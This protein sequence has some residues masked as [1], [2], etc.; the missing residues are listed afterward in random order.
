MEY[1]ALNGS[2]M[3]KMVHSCLKIFTDVNGNKCQTKIINSRVF[4]KK[5]TA[6]NLFTQNLSHLKLALFS[7]YLYLL[8]I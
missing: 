5:I 7:L 8:C 2:E 4:S 6:K 1:S 3:Q